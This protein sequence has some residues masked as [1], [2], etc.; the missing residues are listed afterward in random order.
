MII[1]FDKALNLH[2]QWYAHAGLAVP[3]QHKQPRRETVVLRSRLQG[4]PEHSSEDARW[5]RAMSVQSLIRLAKIRKTSEIVR[6]DDSVQDEI[7]D[8]D[9]VRS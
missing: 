6:C 9:E 7:Y 5:K 2:R 4:Q 1:A 8:G 3:K